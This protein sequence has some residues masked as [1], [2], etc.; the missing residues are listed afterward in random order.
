M[1]SLEDFKDKVINLQDSISHLINEFDN[2]TGVCI[3]SFEVERSKVK[4]CGGENI[5]LP[6]RVKVDLDL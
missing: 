1:I 2:E 5:S 3:S 4:I 6:V